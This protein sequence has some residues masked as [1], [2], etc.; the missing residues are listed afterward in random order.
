MYAGTIIEYID[1]SE[2]PEVEADLG[3][4]DPF[5]IAAFSSEKGPEDPIVISG[6][7]FYKLFV[8]PDNAQESGY[9]IPFA[10]HGQPLLQAANIIDNGGKIYA[11]RVVADDATLANVVIYGSV[12][13]KEDGVAQVGYT[14]SSL[15]NA[16][17][18]ADVLAS[19]SAHKVMKYTGALEAGSYYFKEAEGKLHEFTLVDAIV[20]GDTITWVAGSR[21]VVVEAAG[22]EAVELT[23]TDVETSSLSEV[24]FIENKTYPLLA[25]TD[26]GRGESKKKFRLIP[27]YEYSRDQDFM[28]YNLQIVEENRVLVNPLVSLDPEAIFLNE[29]IAIDN[30]FNA[31]L[32]QI[33]TKF[34]EDSYAEFVAAI[35]D[36]T[37]QTVAEVK[38][39]DIVNGTNRKG[40]PLVE[41][42]TSGAE[43][44]PTVDIDLQNGYGNA[45]LNGSNGAFGNKPIETEEYANKLI[46]FFTGVYTDD[47]YDSD[48][49]KF[50]VIFDANYPNK[51]KRAIED[52]VMFRED[53][54]FFCDFGTKVHNYA[55]IKEIVNPLN[56][57]SDHRHADTKFVAYYHNY[58]DMLDPY[59]KKPITVTITYDLAGYC[60]DH[61]QNG[62]VR[63][64]AGQLYGFTF[65]NAIQGTVNFIPKIIPG[66]NQRQ[67]M[68]D[69]RVNYA[70]Y[71]NGVLTLD[72]EYTSQSKLSQFSYINNVLATQEVVKEIRTLC[73]KNRYTF[74]GQESLNKYK[75]DVESMV[76]TKFRANFDTL[77]MVYLGDS[78][79][80]RNKIFYAGINVRFRDF[81]QTEIFK[82]Y[83]LQ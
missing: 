41:I 22:K 82:V 13:K 53:V 15:G 54:F 32:G 35:A 65:P 3:M 31:V 57:D 5:F 63:P 68:N 12:S 64:F 61:F 42:V 18:Y 7:D 71:Y 66:V 14:Y 81:I 62:R 21:K 56:D 50:D 25:I 78:S 8:T 76:L 69:V 70:V 19:A 37:G 40:E 74:L 58:W 38:A 36:I 55:D 30:Q 16:K 2:I 1:N 28:I 73:P 77:E 24:T 10:K 80:E 60:V 33:K 43:L 52:Y 59:T 29:S 83:A 34:F 67:Q 44:D 39:I 49:Y 26:N 79:Y 9:F 17:T 46:E 48:N 11:K 23:V 75:A 27:N 4:S 51:V 45:L 6:E 20:D 47:V 72:S